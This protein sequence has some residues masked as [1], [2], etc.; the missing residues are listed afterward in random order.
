MKAHPAIGA[1]IVEEVLTGV[2]DPAFVQVAVN[3]AHYH[4]EKVDGTGYPCG[5]KQEEIPL[6][7]FYQ[8]AG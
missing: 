8:S 6:E 4:H 2:E 5:L 3:V 1:R 7:A